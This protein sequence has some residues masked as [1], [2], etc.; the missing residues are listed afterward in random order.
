MKIAINCIFCQPRGGGIKEY[1]YNIVNALSRIDHEN[2]YILYVLK[3][4]MDYARQML[5]DVPNMRIK[6]IPYDSSKL[7]VI[8]RSLFSQLFWSTEEKVEQFDIFHS[9]FFHSPHFQHAK[10]LITVHDLRFCRYPSTYTLLRYLFLREAVKRSIKHADSIISI[11]SFTKKEIVDVYGIEDRKV[12]VVHEAINREDFSLEKIKNYQVEE[13]AQSLVNTRFILSVGHIE[14]RKNYERLLQAFSQLKKR[15]ETSDVKLVIVGKKGHHYKNVL[16]Q[17]ENTPDVHYMNFVS[18]ELLLW[19]Y[20]N[21]SLFAFPS[22]YEGF[23]FPPLEAACFG[24]ISAVANISSIP[25]ICGDSALYFDPFSVEDMESALYRCLCDGGLI[26]KLKQ[27]LIPN[28][29]RFS[30]DRN[31]R[32]TLET[33]QSLQ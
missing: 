10:V 20:K 18:R 16:A 22:F 14:P 31:A 6:P 19:L 25:E 17:M 30:W 13:Q 5:P 9:P 1:I 3:D 33:Y 29:D 26:A 28:L 27:S 11:S 7:S 12:Q 2:Q 21:A 8:K 23:G 4:C 15:P 32:Q 24:T